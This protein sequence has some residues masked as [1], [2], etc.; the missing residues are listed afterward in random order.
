MS[1]HINKDFLPYYRQK[2]TEHE[3]ILRTQLAGQIGDIVRDLKCRNVL[4]DHQARRILT[5]V[6]TRPED[7]VSELI[8]T[9]KQYRDCHFKTFMECLTELG[10]GNLVKEITGSEEIRQYEEIDQG[11]FIQC[12]V[13]HVKPC[14][15]EFVR[16]KL[17][18]GV[19]TM[20][21]KKRGIC[22]I[23]N[24]YFYPEDS[25]GYRKG[26]DKDAMELT[27]LFEDL[28]FDVREEKE[29]K[30][31]EMEQKLKSYSQEIKDSDDCFMLF[32]L[33]HGKEGYVQGT[34]GEFVK[35]D[36]IKDYFSSDK[37]P[38]LKD[39]PKLF[40]IQACQGTRTEHMEL[41]DTVEPIADYYLAIATTPG[42]V[43]YRHPVL[44]S[45]FIQAIVATIK[46]YA[47]E[48]SFKEMMKRIGQK[49]KDVGSRLNPHEM[50]SVNDPAIRKRIVNVA[51]PFYDDQLKKELYFFPKSGTD[52]VR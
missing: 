34:D 48:E 18:T 40:F 39:K 41:T 51:T 16:D 43:A 31:S 45:W 27:A 44:G 6:D 7:C 22:L 17:K 2:Y 13:D 4:Q 11:H 52:L 12:D 42:F 5:G 38:K 3:P 8:D 19:Y 10:Y 46:T 25:Y 49:M 47:C 50:T 23:I 9:L 35:I 29:L 32:I 36:V 24:N 20:K 21:E 28:E 37:C 33:T 30:A 15:P 26:T 14:N 1:A